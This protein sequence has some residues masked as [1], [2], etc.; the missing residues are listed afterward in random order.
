MW[1]AIDIDAERTAVAIAI[2]QRAK[3]GDS[4]MATEKIDD[5]LFQRGAVMR[6]A[7][8]PLAVNDQPDFPMPVAALVQGI[9]KAG[10]A[11]GN[12][13]AVQVDNAGKRQFAALHGDKSCSGDAIEIEHHGIMPPRRG[14]WAHTLCGKATLQGLGDGT[15][16]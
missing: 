8:A 6:R 16:A 5:C 9:I 13:I 2:G 7:V 10:N 14:G 1:P 4:R 15:L 3:G 12:V 11:V